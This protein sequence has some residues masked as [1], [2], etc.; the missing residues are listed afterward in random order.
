MNNDRSLHNE[1]ISEFVSGLSQNDHFSCQS[2]D[3][4]ENLESNLSPE[5]A[6]DF[7]NG[8]ESEIADLCGCGCGQSCSGGS[9]AGL[10]SAC[11]GCHHHD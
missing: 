6:A 2:A 4:H 7:E 9:G 5:L 10:K 3:S 8:L 1:I 11:G